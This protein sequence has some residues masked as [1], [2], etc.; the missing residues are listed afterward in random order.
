[1]WNIWRSELAVSFRQR[2]YFSF[3]VLWVVVLSF[4]F[5]LQSTSPA[6]SGYT[7]ITGT[8]MN[9]LLY[10]IPLFML[11]NGSFSIASEM[12]NGQFRLLSTYPLS[13][14]SYV[15][16]KILGQITSQC[17]MFTLS[18]GISL[19][20]GLLFGV[21]FSAKWAIALYFFAISLLFFF[22]IMGVVIG[23]FSS[24]RWQAL[25][26]SVF[27]WFFLIMLWPT[28]LI[29]TLNLL[30]YPMVGAALKTLL[31]INPAELLRIVF[32]IKLNGGAVF[33]Q[34]YDG[35]TSYYNYDQWISWLGLC[36]YTL[37]VMVISILIS[38]KNL[39]RK[40]RK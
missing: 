21:S 34:A 23:S 16:G 14:V 28:A 40:R 22:L 30:P 35:L 3:V 38:D 19:L 7:N 33:G 26:I 29:S 13:T 5:L 24:T 8:I 2:T 39:T 36:Y 37:V 20:I 32:V 31:Y 9:L 27:I 18:Y 17:L 6:F 11:I 15:I 25:S 1:M 12:E 4:L 10:I